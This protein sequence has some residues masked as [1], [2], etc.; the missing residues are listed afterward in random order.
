MDPLRRVACVDDDPDIREIVGFALRDLGGLE[1]RSWGDGAAFLAEWEAWSPQLVLL[2]L[3]MPGMD[4]ERVAAALRAHPKGGALPVVLLSGSVGTPG[5][6]GVSAVLVK[7]FD[8]LSL[9]GRLR[10][11]WAE[12]GGNGG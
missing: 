8:P 2:D 4:G 1:V 3:W 9:A 10:G 12:W 5:I 11:L 7:P 6:P